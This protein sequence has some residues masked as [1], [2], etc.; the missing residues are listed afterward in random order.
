[1]LNITN[2]TMQATAKSYLDAVKRNREIETVKR[3]A[4]DKL[5]ISGCI[6]MTQINIPAVINQMCVKFYHIRIGDLQRNR[7]RVSIEYFNMQQK[8]N[9][10]FTVSPINNEP[11]KREDNLF[12]WDGNILPWRATIRGPPNTPY[13]GGKFVL[14]IQFD[15]YYPL[16]PL[17]IKFETKIFH[18][19]INQN[20]IDMETLDGA[21]YPANTVERVLL[22]I[23]DL[24]GHPNADNAVPLLTSTILY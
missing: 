12:D 15:D 9:L 3:L 2:Q 23:L 7:R 10:N 1:M 19:N 6:R 22:A 13:D 5:L 11:S 8:Q 18:C 16:R 4:N 14:T 17:K 24:L 20:D 21:W